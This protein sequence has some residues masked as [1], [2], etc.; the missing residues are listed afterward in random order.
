MHPVHPQLCL[1]HNILQQPGLGCGLNT[2]LCVG[3]VRWCITS[4][5]SWDCAHG[6]HQVTSQQIVQFVHVLLDV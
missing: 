1:Q 5:L 6:A 4:L 2:N 3:V